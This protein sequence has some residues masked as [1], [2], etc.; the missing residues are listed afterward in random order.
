MLLTLILGFVLGAGAIVFALQNPAPVALTF[1]NWQFES[2]LAFVIILALAIGGLLGIIS[3]IPSIVRRSL[4]I[5]TLK[6]DGNALRDELRTMEERLE[7]SQREADAL[8][9]PRTVD[10]RHDTLA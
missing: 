6:K 5:R 1:L 9:N 3:A 8:R 2:S 7:A 10:L 4:Y